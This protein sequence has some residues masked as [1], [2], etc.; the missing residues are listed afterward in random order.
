MRKLN[1]DD[2]NAMF[3]PNGMFSGLSK[4]IRAAYVLGIIGPMTRNDLSAIND[5]RNVYAHS[6]LNTRLTSKKMA[7]RIIWIRMFHLVQ[8]HAPEFTFQECFMQALSL[9]AM[10][11]CHDHPKKIRP[12]AHKTTFLGMEAV[13]LLL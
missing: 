3:G 8:K 7:E 10:Y 4:K 2:E 5:I 13:Q 6:P 9:F 11:L 12:K 1:S